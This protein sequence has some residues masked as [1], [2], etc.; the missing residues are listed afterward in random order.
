MIRR[1]QSIKQFGVFE[2]FQWPDS[3][4]EFKQF[5]LIYGWNYSGKTT[6][7]RI[8]GCFEKKKIHEDFAEARVQ[9]ID[10]N[11]MAYDF[12]NLDKS[13][14]IRVFN[15]D[16][17]DDNIKF[18]SG[19]AEP[20]LIL[21]EQDIATLDKLKTK[22]AEREKIKE[23]LNDNKKKEKEIKENIEK[24]L[25]KRASNIKNDFS[26]PNY[27]R[28][29]FEPIV[30]KCQD[31]PECD[32]LSGEDYE[33]FSNIYR[34][35][36]KKPEISY[37]KTVLSP[38]A[39]LQKEA[40]LL[41]ARTI[42]SDKSIPRLK[43]NAS[44]EAW[45]KQGRDLH[46]GK[47]ECQFCGATLPNDFM[48]SLTKHFSEDYDRLMKDLKRLEVDIHAAQEQKI[49]S[50][51]KF[52]FY[53]DLSDDFVREDNALQELLE[54]RFSMLNDL[55]HA[56][57]EKQ[58]KAFS[59]VECPIVSDVTEQI[60]SA[61]KSINGIIEK[62]NV[63]TKE[64]EKNKNN[65]FK[66]L[67]KHCAAQFAIDEKYREKM[68]SIDD[69]KITIENE[70]NNLKKI[71]KDIQ[72]LEHSASEEAI[73]AEKLNKLLMAYFGK[74]DLKIIVSSEKR[75][76]ILRGN[77]IAKNLSEGEKTAI[78]FAYFITR[79]Q[80]RHSD[81]T[82]MTV[83]IDDPISSLDANHLFNTASLITTELSSYSQ[84]IISTHNFEF[85][86]LIR[87]WA[88]ETEKISKPMSKW[89]N[90]CLLLVKRGDN[91]KSI[92]EE[93][94]K[95]LLKFKSEY[96]YLF[97]MLHT[98]DKSGAG[99]FNSLL[100]LPNVVRR[101]MEAFGGIMI[102]LS[103]GL[104]QKMPRFFPDELERRRVEKFINHYSHQTTITR[105]L[106]IPDTS[107]C[108]SVVKLCLKA[109]QNWNVDYFKDLETAIT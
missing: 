52:E 101:F 45:V 14:E 51:N 87:D 37:I 67:E 99:D 61:I 3:L 78:A 66:K 69:L 33:K 31:E 65:A 20:I 13:P 58:T 104:K 21:G 24:A 38:I 106:Q 62:H 68:K 72:K 80:D 97:S 28:N 109:V 9:L 35:N 89:E 75:F 85:Y 107:E 2:D 93:I 77:V 43:E 82:K 30:K 36:D 32:L 70:N 84:L 25:T 11:G 4:P 81:A 39:Q 100:S 12:F 15:N 54:V 73:G 90:W 98:F 63:R 55:A 10:E 5:N 50:K 48:E 79:V 47:E 29:S 92:L 94:P 105:S 19:T 16:F 102:P 53:T 64:F 59:V 46:A 23:S 95:E 41:L 96:H 1:V 56:V 74:D 88:I 40:A 42:S 26:E 103:T 8:F 60:A 17:I 57:S 18:T 86:N 34:S 44:I 27:N 108:I 71:N 49:P 83:V 76:Q 22:Q 91:E 7:S 6:L